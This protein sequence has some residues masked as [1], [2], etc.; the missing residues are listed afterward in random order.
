MEAGSFDAQGLPNAKSPIADHVAVLSKLRR[1]RKD[2]SVWLNTAEGM[3]A[4]VESW[5]GPSVLAGERS[6]RDCRH[7]IRRYE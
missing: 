3:L 2:S 5:R 4:L 1:P 7:S 6:A